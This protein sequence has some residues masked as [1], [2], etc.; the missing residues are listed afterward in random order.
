MDSSIFLLILRN[1]A[2]L[3]KMIEENAPYDKIL[4]QSKRL[5][6]YIMTQ[7]KYINKV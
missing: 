7:M 4:R 5:D 1:K 3:S 2:K 6:K